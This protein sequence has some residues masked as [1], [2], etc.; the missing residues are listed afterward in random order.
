MGYSGAAAAPAW[1]STLRYRL[2]DIE[3]FVAV[4]EAGSVS[5]AA[6]RLDVAKSVVSKRV[7]ALEDCLGVALLQR[8]TRRAMP[9]ADGMAFFERSKAVMQALDEAAQA[10]G[11]RRGLSGTRSASP[12]P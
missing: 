5:A 8:S 11:G 1:G 9:T 4:V 2:E 6:V 12:C 3:A 10:V 7:T